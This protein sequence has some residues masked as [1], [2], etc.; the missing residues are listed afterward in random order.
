MRS[1]LVCAIACLAIPTASTFAQG[2]RDNRTLTGVGTA[3]I[4]GTVVSDER[5]ARPLRRARV[6]ITGSEL[7]IGRTTVTADDGT[8]SFDQLPAGRYSVTASKDGY[9]AMRAGADRPGR[10]GVG[11]EVRQGE[12]ARTTL[13][14]PK[15]AVITGIVRLPNGE[16]ASGV[17]VTPLMRRYVPATRVSDGS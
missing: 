3:A 6:S 4:T 7:D 15:G 8:F 2:V 11:V 10:P 5:A 17:T 12:T 1:L 13:R 14:L 16:P 9:V